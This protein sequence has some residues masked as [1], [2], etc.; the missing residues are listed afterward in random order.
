M[1][2][3]EVRLQLEVVAPLEEPAQTALLNVDLVIRAL[4]VHRQVAVALLAPLVNFKMQADSGDV[5]HAH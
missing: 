2:V 4:T 3:Q 1:H 5:P